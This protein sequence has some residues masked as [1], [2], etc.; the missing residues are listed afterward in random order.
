M[1]PASTLIPQDTLTLPYGVL[2][3]IHNGSSEV[4]L[5]RDLV[6]GQFRVGKRLSL[7]GRD[8]HLIHEA[9]FLAEVSHPNVAEMYV[10]AEPSG[11]D[12]LLEMVE[13]MMPYYE[14][15][16]VLDALARGE[17]FGLS[18]G[19]TLM[20]KALRGLAHVHD[21]HHVLHRDVKPGNLFLTSDS[22][23]VK[24]GDFGE[25]MRMD[26]AGKCDPLISPQFW[27]SPDTFAGGRYS[28]DSDVFS[29][30]MTLHEVW[31]GPFPYEE[32]EVADLTARLAQGRLAVLPRHL[33]FAPHV[34]EVLRRVVRKACRLDPSDRFQTADAMREALRRAS[35]ID[36]GWP[37]GDEDSVTWAG[38]YS[39]SRYEVRSR[40]LR[41]GTWRASCSKL[42]RTGWR[43]PAG[44]PPVDAETADLAAQTLFAHMERQLVR[45]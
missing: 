21:H 41:N 34:P 11:H 43:Q 33:R 20:M 38:Q 14:K 8:G 19:R 15:G 44:C 31:N 1:T 35:F 5:Y 28:V 17:R 39:G 4:R 16:S 3:T 23:V 36:W 7:L 6:T 30:A 27:T 25:A 18:Q 13:L 40:R 26:S 9:A 10:V 24:V 12:S 22:R 32:Y 42:H 45:T 37:T 29:M 2:K